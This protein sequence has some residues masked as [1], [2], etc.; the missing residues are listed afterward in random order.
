MSTGQSMKLFRKQM[1]MHWQLYA[2][3]LLPLIS[4]IIFKYIPIYGIVISFKSY[5]PVKGISGSQWVGMKNFRQFFLSPSSFT[6]IRNTLK[7]SLF[8]LIFS[9]P[10]PVLLAVM[11]NECK[12]VRY[13]K[14]VQMV[15]YLPYFISTV[16]LVGIVLQ[17]TDTHTG[18]I[19]IVLSNMG[20]PTVNFMGKTNLFVPIYVITDIWSQ[21]GYNSVLYLAA[22]TGVSPELHEAA[23]MDGASRVNRIIHIDLPSIMPTI[24]LMMIM[25]TGNIMNLGY[26]KVFLMQND[27]NIDV[28]EI[29]STYVYK[30]GL[31]NSNYSFSTAI[32]FMNTIVSL[33]MVTISNA[34]AKKLSGTSMW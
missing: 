11:L 29:I 31:Q 26:E 27:I 1:K 7:I 2:I 8:S 21:T 17:V 3:F 19:N 20:K 13:R 14:T 18:A 10:F 16:V 30:V 9:F 34:V 15:T 32:G 23:V 28:S 4:L 12:M 25:R 33:F 22:L 6:I 5:N 24:V